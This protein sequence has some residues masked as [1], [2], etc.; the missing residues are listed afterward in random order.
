MWWLEKNFEDFGG[1]EL[2]Q[3]VKFQASALGR[4]EDEHIPMD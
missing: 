3:G 2:V 1:G 4:P